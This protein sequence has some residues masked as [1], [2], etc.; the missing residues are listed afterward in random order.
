VG[1]AM[2][3]EAVA[4]MRADGTLPDARFV[5]VHYSELVRDP[6]ATLRAIGRA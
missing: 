5:D 1:V 4:S 2:L 6:V 3:F